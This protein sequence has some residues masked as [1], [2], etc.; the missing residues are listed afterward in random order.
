M[1]SNRILIDTIKE[2]IEEQY[3]DANL[4]LQSIASAMKLSSAHIS[5]QFRQQES[6]SISEY[7]N[8]VRLRNA[9]TLLEN[10]DYSISRIMDM[11][12]YSNESYFFKLF[13]K[14]FGTTPKEYRFKKVIED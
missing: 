7:I 3:V 1:Q 14:K 4:N 5:K 9:L 13:K 10:K 11:V 12:G 2:M 6:M 8:E